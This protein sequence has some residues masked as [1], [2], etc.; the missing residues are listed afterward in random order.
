VSGRLLH[1]LL[2]ASAEAGPDRLAVVDG[3]RTLTYGELERRG[4]VLGRLLQEQGV[5]RG[6]RVGLFLD[7]SLE[8][9]VGIYGVLKSGATYVP[10]DPNAPL[11]RLGYIARDAD[12]RCLLTAGE[13]AQD[14]DGLRE[15]GAPLE[16]LV[17][18]N[19]TEREPVPAPEG[20]RVVSFPA[21]LGA[22]AESPPP[23]RIDD[24]DLAY[25]LY[26]SGSTGD[27]KGVMLSHLNARA[28][29]DWAV[30]E[31]DVSAGDRLSSHAPLHFDLSVFDLFAA[32]AAGAPV[33]L[34]PPE[35]SIFPVNLA[36]FMAESEISVWYSVPSILTL[37]VTRGDLGA[38]E[39][40]SLRAVLFAGEVFPTKY[41]FRL[42]ELLPHVRFANLYG[43]TETNVCTWY[44]VPPSPEG[45]PD[46][47]PIGKPITDVDVFAV[48]DDG[49]LA[50]A[51]EVGEL[52]V[53]GPTVMHGYWGDQERTARAFLEE[54]GARAAG[55]GRAYRTGDLVREDEEGNY[56]YLGRRDAQIKS[57][58]YRIELGEIETAL[59]AH[60]SV[61]ECAVTTIPDELVGNRIKAYVVVRD[62][63]GQTDLA[64]FCSKRIPH[65]M[66]P[67][68]Y[69]FRPELPKTSTGK[70]DRKAL[71]AEGA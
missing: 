51:G 44:E 55:G 53:R 69:E 68:L 66:V 52:C 47:I 31:F 35:L 29:V 71:S 3:R 24:S 37:L 40:P 60:P 41:L 26:T 46:A 63:L 59:Y 67:E 57:R 23:M 5:Q 34:V 13:K 17:V 11:A 50:G 12:I 38:V 30:D 42:M 1:E 16:S 21:A 27:P 18:L 62:D 8:S 19:A 6:D 15:G 56:W 39:L 32:A 65:Y 4:N 49:R 64:A 10:F 14:W 25:I 7:K 48:T 54:D 28:F 20:V 22:Y 33:V 2:E 43:P 58:G 36:G 9:L 61:V 70:V 45:R